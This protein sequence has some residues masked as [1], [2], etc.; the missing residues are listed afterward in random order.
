MSAPLSLNYH[1]PPLSSDN[2]LPKCPTIITA[3]ENKSN[4]IN[5]PTQP[6][7]CLV[8]LENCSNMKELKQIHAQMLRTGLFFDAYS[9]SRIV[10]FCALQQSGN[11]HY[12]RLALTQIANPTTFTCNSIIRGY[13]NKNLPREA[14]VFY[15]E[16][17]TQ[18][19]MSRIDSHFLRCSN[20]VLICVKGNSCIVIRLSLVSLRILIFR[21]R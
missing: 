13:T 19:L 10:A 16:M 17:I 5:N 6:H 8:S 20:R 4:I 3:T 18:G 15:Q 21:T 1:R 12:A 2:P 9:A 11:L 7:P 14:I